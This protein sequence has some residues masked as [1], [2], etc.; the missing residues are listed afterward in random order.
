MTDHPSK[1]AALLDD[2][3]WAFVHETERYYPAETATMEIAEQRA[4]Y[5]RMCRAFHHGYPDAV[6][7]MDAVVE[8]VPV[9]RYR[10][11]GSG[12]SGR[13]VYFHG[14]GFVVGGLESHDDVCAELCAGTGL[15]VTAVDYPLAPE[16]VFPADY[17]ACLAVT[18][19]VLAEGDGPVLL[20][21]DSAGGSLCASVSAALRGEARRPA[22]QVLIYPGLSGD[23]S[24]P[25]FEEHSNAPMLTRDDCIFY[26]SVRTGGDEA[27]LAD[28]RCSPLKDTD[29]AGLP[30]TVAVAAECDPLADNAREYVSKIRAAGGDARLIEEPGLVHG[31][32]RA[33]A[34]VTRAR[35]SFTR[36][37]GAVD[38]LAARSGG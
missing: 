17:E 25:S 12:R 24:A 9:R 8:G 6:T 35:E 34:T 30:P 21:G 10:M 7:A 22:G 37:V 18:R 33:R 5:D 16:Q 32:L 11:A 19:A 31:Y 13:V 2:E 26:K 23:V 29:F 15:P 14:G 3:V 20:V 38:E 36:I 1:Y 4:I 28:P 27:K